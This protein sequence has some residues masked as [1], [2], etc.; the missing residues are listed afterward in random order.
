MSF[1]VWDCFTV[2]NGNFKGFTSLCQ[3]CQNYLSYRF[4]FHLPEH[5][6]RFYCVF[7]GDKK[8]LRWAGTYVSSFHASWDASVLRISSQGVKCVPC[9]LCHPVYSLHLPPGPPSIWVQQ[10]WQQGVVTG[11][12]TGYDRLIGALTSRSEQREMIRRC[13]V[14]L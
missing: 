7:V 11:N 1:S 4:L 13:L 12:Q 3:C 6:I 14:C 10:S 5:I 8:Q 9:P 2:V